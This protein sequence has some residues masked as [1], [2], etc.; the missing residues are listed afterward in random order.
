VENTRIRVRQE[1][2]DSFTGN[3]YGNQEKLE[4][5]EALIVGVFMYLSGSVKVRRQLSMHHVGV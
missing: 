5:K 3:Y 2:F 4:S 1:T